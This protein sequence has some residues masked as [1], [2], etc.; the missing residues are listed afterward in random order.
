MFP[1]FHSSTDLLH[2]H[3]APFSSLT[4]D[5]PSPANPRPTATP[6]GEYNSYTNTHTLIPIPAALCPIS[7]QPLLLTHRRPIPAVHPH[8]RTHGDIPTPLTLSHRRPTPTNQ[9]GD[10]P[11]P[12]NKMD[13]TSTNNS[14]LRLRPRLRHCGRTTA[15]S[16][17]EDL[18]G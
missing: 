13:S 6:D 14:N 4:G 1:P 18:K 8:R 3:S 17:V 2:F 9:T 12:I 5:P 16:I 15:I 7:T 10:A 11:S